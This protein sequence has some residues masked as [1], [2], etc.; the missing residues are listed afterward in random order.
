MTKSAIGKAKRQKKNQE[1]KAAFAITKKQLIELLEMNRVNELVITQTE[2]EN[3]WL[4][5]ILDGSKEVNFLATKRV[6][7]EPRMFRRI[8]VIRRF[9]AR[10]LAIEC[11]IT[12]RINMK[13]Y[14]RKNKSLVNSACALLFA[15]LV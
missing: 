12:L 11:A 8:D 6:A 10:D 13:L 3:Y 15:R 5:A 1:F 7:I 14:S 9:L 4:G 2:K